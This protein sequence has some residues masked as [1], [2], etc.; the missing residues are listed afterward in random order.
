VDESKIKSFLRLA[1]Q[2]E[3]MGEFVDRHLDHHVRTSS[4]LPHAICPSC[5]L[6]WEPSGGEQV[7]AAHDEPAAA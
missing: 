2:L 7:L 1:R 3:A 5:G 4:A 6:F